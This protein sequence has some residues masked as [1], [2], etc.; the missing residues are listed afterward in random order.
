[1]RMKAIP[2]SSVVAILGSASETVIVGVS[3]R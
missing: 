1:M 2:R 3:E